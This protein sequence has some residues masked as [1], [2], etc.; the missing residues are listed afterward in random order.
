MAIWQ[1]ADDKGGWQDMLPEDMAALEE[2]AHLD[3]VEILLGPYRFRY[4]VDMAVMRQ[5]NV[6]TGQWRSLRRLTDPA[7]EKQVEAVFAGFAASTDG[8]AAAGVN[9][10]R[11]SDF[12]D[13]DA[14]L[15]SNYWHGAT[16]Q[17]LWP[18]SAELPPGD[19]QQSSRLSSRRRSRPTS[20]NASLPTTP[21]ERSFSSLDGRSAS[22]ESRRSQRLPGPATYHN[23]QHG[24][25]LSARAAVFGSTRRKTMMT[26]DAGQLVRSSTPGPSDYNTARAWQKSSCFNSSPRVCMK[27]TQR[28]SFRLESGRVLL[29]TNGCDD[30]S[31]G[32]GNYDTRRYKKALSPVGAA[33]FGR[34]VRLTGKLCKETD[35]RRPSHDVAEIPP[36]SA[37]QR[38]PSRQSSRSRSF[39]SDA[40]AA[41]GTCRGMRN[42]SQSQ[43]AASN[44]RLV[45]ESE[46]SAKW[47][48]GFQETQ[49]VA[50][51]RHRDA[52]RGA[53]QRSQSMSLTRRRHSRSN[54]RSKDILASDAE[55]EGTS[56]RHEESRGPEEYAA[57]ASEGSLPQRRG[58]SV[59][60][61]GVS[62]VDIMPPHGNLTS[63]SRASSIERRSVVSAVGCTTGTTATAWGGASVRGASSGQQISSIIAPTSQQHTVRRNVSDGSRSSL[64]LGSLSLNNNNLAWGAWR[65]QRQPRT[66]V[67]VATQAQAVEAIGLPLSSTRIQAQYAAPQQINASSVIPRVITSY[68]A[69]PACRSPTHISPYSVQTDSGF[70]PRPF[71]DIGDGY[72]G[73]C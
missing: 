67:Q 46:A 47:T 69:S 45:L 5:T 57:A 73:C 36:V 66:S 53:R 64:S 56:V 58:S 68:S 60:H 6:R 61:R 49:G 42:T 44:G 20:R 72:V 34:S 16:S 70:V 18:P 39:S 33:T 25:S 14:F 22:L 59:E 21:R 51:Q 12:V 63:V 23:S 41:P 65:E 8:P 9:H 2:V 11:D 30:Q 55:L 3:R 31:P 28:K 71:S 40:R 54:S 37:E 62:S 43:L 24:Q 1:F 50:N 35:P 7:N 13:A 17:S 48:Q 15:G 29:D 27:T 52:P 10:Q 38:M 4:L 19:A 26:D 32:P